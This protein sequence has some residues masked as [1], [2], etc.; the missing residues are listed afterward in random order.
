[1]KKIIRLVSIQLWA[2]IGDILSIGKNRS[3][4][5]KLLYVG[6]LLFVLLM[7][8]ISF[9]YNMMIGQGF[10]MYDSLD[11]LPAMMMAATCLVILMTTIFKV[12][13]TIF[14]F[15]DYDM[16]MSLP[17]STGSIVF[18]RLI[19]LYILNFLFV[20]IIIVPMMIAYGIL[21][22]PDIMFYITCIITMFFIPFLPIVIASLLGTLIAYIAS[23]FKH[24]NIFSIIFS[25]ALIT[26]IVGA[27]FLL[28]NNGQE[29]VDMSKA[30]TN[31]VYS[32]YPLASMYTNA[33][34]RCAISDLLLFIGISILAFCAY[35]I[36]VKTIFKKM[37]TL[38]MTGNYHTN[39]KLGQ[40]K[41]SSPLKALYQKELKRYF[42]STI[43]V[44]NTS[45]GIVMLTVGAIALI[46]VDLDKALGNSEAV[47]TIV[48]CIPVIISFCITMSCTTMAS[49][50][51]EGKNL[52]IIK[53][54]PI[55]PK[56]IYLS[57]VA[58]NLTIL[59]PVILDTIIIGIAL[60]L[61]IIQVICFLM[62]VVALSIFIALY[63]LVLNLLLPNLNWTSEVVVVKQSAAT[64]ITIF[65][66]MV[67]VAIQFVFIS[68]ISSET[69]AYLAYFLLTVVIDVVLYQILKTF[70]N[71]RYLEL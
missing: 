37:N 4:K 23:K 3:K 24:R 70:G 41:T 19:I 33:V 21:A 43:Y 36:I 63:G 2:V 64:M 7:S 31:Q 69:V 6:V 26:L 11:I 62:I 25:F 10:Q 48:K 39:Y 35:T 55:T 32:I 5:P 61:N 18:S 20:I 54:M 22:K 15:R 29:L 47:D 49:I 45:F 53:A 51:L 1:M 44:L 14:G 38:L 13:G 42:S 34:V 65:T 57:K 50:S 56:M 60:K 17:V 28:K 30:L 68:L 16:V 67:Y 8:L 66:S 12:K 40:L 9:M 27:S 58:V 52:W 59:A 71:K 46:F